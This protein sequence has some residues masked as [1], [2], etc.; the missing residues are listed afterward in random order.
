M[1]SLTDTKAMIWT[2]RSARDNAWGSIYTERFEGAAR[3]L[4][5]AVRSGPTSLRELV[6][7]LGEPTIAQAETFWEW[8]KAMSDVWE[9]AWP[10]VLSGTLA[11]LGIAL[12]MAAPNKELRLGTTLF[13]NTLE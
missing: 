13:R 9:E 1:K 6:K 7:S 12:L 5:M 8:E 4:D 2:A 11:T 3:T 10:L